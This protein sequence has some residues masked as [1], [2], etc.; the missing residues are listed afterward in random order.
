MNVIIID[1]RG[2][3]SINRT[4]VWILYFWSHPVE[5][6]VGEVMTIISLF[7][8]EPIEKDSLNHF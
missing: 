7:S 6:M 5:D 1:H 3:D 8:V 2:L 4:P